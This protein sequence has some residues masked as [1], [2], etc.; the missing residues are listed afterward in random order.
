MRLLHQTSAGRISAA[1]KTR[2]HKTKDFHSHPP[3][4]FFFGF[5]QL[6]HQQIRRLSGFPLLLQSKSTITS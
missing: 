3:T 4:F 2:Q 5:I 1:F 6:I